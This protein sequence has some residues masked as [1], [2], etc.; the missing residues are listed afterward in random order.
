MVW[1]A[2]LAYAERLT[3]CWVYDDCAVD[4]SVWVLT[5]VPSTRTC[6]V[7]VNGEVTRPLRYQYVKVAVP[8]GMTTAWD[9]LAVWLDDVS[10][11]NLAQWVPV[12]GGDVELVVE[13]FDDEHSGVPL[14]E[15]ASVQL[16]LLG[17]VPVAASKPPSWMSSA[18][19]AGPIRNGATT[20]ADATS[21][22]LHAADSR[23]RAPMVLTKWPPTMPAEIDAEIDETSRVKCFAPSSVVP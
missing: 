16:G 6:S 15:S 18:A 11:P 1:L 10:A 12:R 9:R 22:V 4:A 19:E 23:R 13:Q 20:R 14:R 21:T 3:V 7:A 17:G 8:A 2:P 5:V